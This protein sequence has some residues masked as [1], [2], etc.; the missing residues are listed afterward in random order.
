[1]IL[2]PL[3]QSPVINTSWD[4]PSA[5]YENVPCFNSYME[6]NDIDSYECPTMVQMNKDFPART[7]FYRTRWGWYKAPNAEFQPTYDY[8]MI[9]PPFTLVW[10]S[11]NGACN[12]Y[13]TRDR[14][15]PLE[16]IRVPT[17][18]DVIKLAKRFEN[19]KV[20]L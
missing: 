2:C 11:N 20:F 12:I 4:G 3:C 7:H 8:N 5:R 6:D 19:M 18:E 14:H 17:L 9:I 10:S 13:D 16:V 1:M 15:L